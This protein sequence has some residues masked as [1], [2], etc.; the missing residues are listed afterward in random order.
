MVRS[1]SRSSLWRRD[2]SKYFQSI[3]PYTVIIDCYFEPCV[4]KRNMYNTTV[5]SILHIVYFIFMIIMFTCCVCFLHCTKLRGHGQHLCDCNKNMFCCN[6]I[7]NVARIP[8]V[9][10]FV[11]KTN[12]LRFKN[13]SATK[14]IFKLI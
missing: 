5:Y 3:L 6:R 2:F 1:H 11:A 8:I 10:F 14:K 7:K 12:F 9:I 13:I 4:M